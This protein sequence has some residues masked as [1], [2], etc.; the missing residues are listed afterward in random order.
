MQPASSLMP[1]GVARVTLPRMAA[2]AGDAAALTLESCGVYR[3]SF[4]LFLALARATTT[5][6]L[7]VCVLTCIFSASSLE[8]TLL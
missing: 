3:T 8:S 1:V 2:A 7:L 4:C 6:D 5:T